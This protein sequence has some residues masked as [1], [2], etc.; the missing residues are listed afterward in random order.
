[1]RCTKH[2]E[3]V[4]VPHLGRKLETDPESPRYTSFERADRRRYRDLRGERQAICH[5]GERVPRWF[6][7]GSTMVVIFGL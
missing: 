4:R 6:D 2:R 5:G 1:M 7:S 3:G